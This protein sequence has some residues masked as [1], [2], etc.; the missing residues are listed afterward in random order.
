MKI[1]VVDDE[2]PARARLVRMLAE[3]GQHDVHEASDAPSARAA[4]ER[5]PADVVLLDVSMPGIDGLSF[6]AMT[7]LPAVVFVTGDP[8]HA[9]RA[10]DVEAADF[11]TKPVRRDRLA[12]A[13]ER[14]ARVSVAAVGADEAPVRLRVIDG[15]SERFVDGRHIDVF[16]AEHKCVVF[17]HGGREEVLRC[18]L[19]E[20][21]AQLGADHHV[22]AHRG[23][24]VRLAAIAELRGGDDGAALVTTSGVEVPVSRRALA[25]VR[26][27]L[28]HRVALSG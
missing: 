3:L 12:R 10:F 26:A 1:L 24:L 13:L 7:R 21:E 20:L 15:T 2:P 23:F 4:L 28:K 6:A 16:R 17:E 9:A 5:R 22:R 11:V 14:A 18:S 25:T 27:A 19:D 8:S